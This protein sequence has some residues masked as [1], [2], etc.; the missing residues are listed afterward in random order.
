MCAV[1][2]ECIASAAAERKKQKS[3]VTE[4]TVA[5]KVCGHCKGH[6]PAADFHRT[7]TRSDGL[8]SSCKV[9]RA[10]EGGDFIGTLGSMVPACHREKPTCIME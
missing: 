6:K 9:H 1:A 5:F 4:P 2:Q 7:R 3:L 10:R 8:S